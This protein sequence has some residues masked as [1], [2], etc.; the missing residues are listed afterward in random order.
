MPNQ[1]TIKPNREAAD[2]FWAYWEEH[3]EAGDESGYDST[4]GA[5]NAALAVAG[6]V[7]HKVE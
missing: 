4:I 5:I 3:R 7:Y 6:V 2:A 1:A